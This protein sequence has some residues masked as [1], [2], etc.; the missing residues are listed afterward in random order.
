MKSVIKKML[1]LG[2]IE[3]LIIYYIFFK[4]YAF[5]YFFDLGG[6]GILVLTLLTTAVI[7]IPMYMIKYYIRKKDCFDISNFK[8]EF[9]SN[10]EILYQELYQEHIVDLEVKRKK[11]R[12]STIIFNFFLVWTFVGYL[13]CEL[14]SVAISKAIDSQIESSTLFAILGL[15]AVLFWNGKNVKEYK[16]KYKQEIVKTFIDSLRKNI[17]YNPDDVLE[18]KQIEQCYRAAAFDNK[19]FNRFYAD[20]SIEGYI[21]NEVY[22]KIADLQIKHVTG[23][24]KNKSVVIRFEGLFAVTNCKANFRTP[25]KISKNAVPLLKAVNAVELDNEEFERFFDVYSDE[26]ILAVRI[27]THDVMECLLDFYQKYKIQYEL[28]FKGQV[29]NIRFYTGPMFEPKIFGSSMDKELLYVYYLILKFVIDL[30]KTVNKELQ[31]FEI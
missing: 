9:D 23:S 31:N 16:T 26:K 19:S 7:Y 28:V 3:I 1:L 11:A 6:L 29:I 18:E 15:I 14:E 2:I 12:L 24:G 30:T 21:D 27:L 17:T 4:G 22:A 25:V 8:G 10:F 20:D 13:F 5:E